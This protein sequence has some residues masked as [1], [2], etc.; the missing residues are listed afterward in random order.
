MAASVNPNSDPFRGGG[1]FA[2][3]VPTSG[4]TGSIAP[5]STGGSLV[6]GVQGSTP[7]LARNSRGSNITIPYARVVLHP[8]GRTALPAP[9]DKQD[10]KRTTLGKPGGD[11][12]V[13]TE[14]LFS[15][16]IGF[17]LGRRAKAYS[18][19]GVDQLLGMEAMATGT[20]PIN[21]RTQQMLHQFAVGGVDQHTMQRMCSFEYLE[22]YFY[23]V[24]R[25]KAI[26]LGDRLYA[27]SGELPAKY[28]SAGVLAAVANKLNNV[29]AEAVIKAMAKAE[30]GAEPA[31][32]TPAAVG[33]AAV[34]GSGIFAS[35]DGPFLRG[36]TLDTYL[37]PYRRNQQK[38][39]LGI[40][41][42]AAFE[43][44]EAALKNIGALEWSPDG[45]V[46]SKLDSGAGS[47]R[48]AD[49]AIDAR[50][51][52]LYNVTI[53]G[54]AV[55]SSWTGDPMM[56][57]LPLDKVFIVIVGDVWTGKKA[58]DT[59]TPANGIDKVWEEDAAGTTKYADAF[60]AHIKADDRDATK[61][62]DISGTRGATVATPPANQTITN[63][64]V[65]KMTSS[66]M[67]TY[68]A[69]VPGSDRSRL[70][71]KIGKDG[72]EYILGGWCIGTV[73][74]SAAARAM[75]DGMSLVGS[76]KRAR[77]SH[78]ANV[79]V[80]IKWC[81]AD[82][83]YHKYMNRG[84]EASGTEKPAGTLRSRYDMRRRPLDPFNKPKSARP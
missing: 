27:N 21:S 35:D 49:D 3:G 44:F 23:H 77:S 26:D 28:K 66:Q 22:R 50:D 30:T 58:T 54:P 33:A 47:D 78:A 1:R 59:T 31:A 76:V 13:E 48:L 64:R 55:T 4:P 62:F 25:T 15:G 73:L 46:L 37:A 36:R 75:P 74:D 71:L 9:P 70:G 8:A 69:Y 79:L 18:N 51:G 34:N 11:L 7:M 19:S 52:Q 83:L 20:Q 56:E 14:H 63:F 24:L 39:S 17:I 41:N 72:G 6:G 68:S 42:R 38:A 29:D 2:A 67:V 60:Q 82:E 81:S 80:D 61:K 84:S 65:K 45:I 10:P 57:V 53:G 5:A 16:R 40:G 43:A 32:G 12:M